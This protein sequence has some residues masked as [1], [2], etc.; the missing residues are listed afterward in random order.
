MELELA[1]IHQ[2]ADELANRGLQF[3]IAIQVVKHENEPFQIHL[4]TDEAKNEKEVID[5]ILPFFEVENK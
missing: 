4:C 5:A 1:T 3:I 2:I